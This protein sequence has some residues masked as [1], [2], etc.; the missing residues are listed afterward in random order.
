MP[1]TPHRL[2]RWEH[3]VPLRV[4]SIHLIFLSER[5]W[6]YLSLLLCNH[7]C[8]LLSEKEGPGLL[9]HGSWAC[10]L[11]LASAVRGAPAAAAQ[12]ACL[13]TF[14][15]V[16]AARVLGSVRSACLHHCQFGLG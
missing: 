10:T 4:V 7:I 11:N 6:V 2:Q 15:C 16:L 14:L 13:I 8:W 9:L 12:D 1:S 3:W 5:T